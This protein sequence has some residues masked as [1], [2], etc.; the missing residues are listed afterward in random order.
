MKKSM[1]SLEKYGL[2][3]NEIARL[4]SNAEVRAEDEN[5]S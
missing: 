4:L 1:H 2:A 5:I 3:T